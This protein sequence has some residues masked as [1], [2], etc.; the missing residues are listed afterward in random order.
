MLS[1]RVKLGRL[2]FATSRLSP[3][4]SNERRANVCTRL[5]RGQSVL[6]TKSSISI[7]SQ[8]LDVVTS[9]CVRSTKAKGKE[10][11]ALQPVAISEDRFELVMGKVTH[12][13]TEFLHHV[14]KY[15]C[16]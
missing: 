9:S 12:E 8:C 15:H 11:E 4:K 13:R 10:P 2:P 16:L 3:S 7:K 6:L 14:R 5:T 1:G